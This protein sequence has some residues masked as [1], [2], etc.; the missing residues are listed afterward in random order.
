MVNV[1]LGLW[2]RRDLNPIDEVVEANLE[3]FRAH[4][5]VSYGESVGRTVGKTHLQI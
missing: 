4:C 1:L 3:T 2:T 5:Y